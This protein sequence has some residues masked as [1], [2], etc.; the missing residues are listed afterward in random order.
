MSDAKAEAPSTESKASDVKPPE[1]K[2]AEHKPAEAKPVEVAKPAEAKPAEVK[3]AEA[4]PAAAKPAPAPAAAAAKTPESKPAEAKAPEGPKPGSVG[5]RAPAPKTQEGAV[6]ITITAK[7]AMMMMGGLLMLVVL[8]GGTTVFLLVRLTDRHPLERVAWQGPGQE[9]KGFA[10]ANPGAAGAAGAGH[11]SAETPATAAAEKPAAEAPEK[12]DIGLNFKENLGGKA[13]G[14]TGSWPAFRGPKY[15]NI[16]T[17]VPL[18]NK[19]PKAG[20]PVKWTIPELGEGYSGAAA[21][22]GRMYLQDYDP[23][24]KEESLRCFSM[25]DGKEIWRR[26]YPLKIVNNHGFTRTVPAI[27]EKYAVSM[28]SKCHV[29]CVDAQTGALKWGLDLMKDYGSKMPD[30]YTA[31]CPIIDGTNAIIA[32]GGKEVLIMG[33]DLESGKIV[34]KTP[35]PGKLDMSH[36]SVTPITFKGKKMYAYCAEWGKMVGVSAEPADAGTLLWEVVCLDKQVIAPSPLI[37]DDGYIFMTAGYQGGSSLVQLTEA[38]GKFEAKVLWK[39]DEKEGLSCEQQTP[40][41]YNK[42]IYALLPDSSGGRKQQLVCMNPYDKGKIIWESGKEKRFGQYEP[43]L[44]AD[45]KFFVLGKDCALTLVKAST[46]KYEE[47][48][49]CKILQGH[50][51]WAPI[52]LVGDRLLIRDSKVLVCLDVGKGIE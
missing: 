18:A 27:N 32:P 7:A 50:D 11:A 13:G 30:W 44:L 52:A 10:A 42:H 29:M 37:L 24:N 19:W 4:K 14:P 48:G 41:Y 36:S 3:A 38:G 34:W 35:N 21:L 46:Q 51:A 9:G 1:P 12:V 43:I 31:Q 22:G 40:V 15:D 25:E 23:K 39:L 47:L 26:S 33:V 5:V 28:G 6:N 45:G 49:Q 8:L 17:D 20:P 16:A 2:P